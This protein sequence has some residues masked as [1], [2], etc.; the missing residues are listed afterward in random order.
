MDAAGEIQRAGKDVLQLSTPF[1]LALDVTDHAA[2]IGP[3][4]AQRFVG[5]VELMG[6]R[7]ALMLDQRMLAAPRVGL[8]QCDASSPGH[9]VGTSPSPANHVSRFGARGGTLPT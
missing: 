5:T 7:K 8:A 6:V 2:K 9:S 1:D 4:S 3:Q